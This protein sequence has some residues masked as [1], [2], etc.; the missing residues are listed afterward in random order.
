MQVIHG[1]LRMGRRRENRPLVLLQDL[2]PTD[3]IGRVIFA[4]LWRD[5]QVRAEKRR[6]DL[7][8]E[9]L[10]GIAWHRQSAGARTP[11]SDGTGGRVTWGQIASALLHH[12]FGINPLRESKLLL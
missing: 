10:H 4:R 1:A 6:A 5:A 3:E 9:F 11:G 12:T 8:H 7:G 2:E